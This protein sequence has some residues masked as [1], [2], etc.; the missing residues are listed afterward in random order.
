MRAMVRPVMVVR[1]SIDPAVM[2]EFLRW[3]REVHLPHVMQIPGIVR[4]YRS[5]CYR[6]G[7]NWATL[8]EFQ[9][10]SVIQEAITSPQASQARQD[11]EAWLPHVSEL[12]VE[13]Y[14]SLSPLPPYHHW[15]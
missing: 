1:A 10:D 8:Y 15:N 14:A 4:A 13:V 6:H 9:D 12:T 2:E 7:I 5:N 11:W 3:Y